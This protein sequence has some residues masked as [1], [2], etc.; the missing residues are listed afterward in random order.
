MK[1][2]KIDIALQAL[3]FIEGF[4]KDR[5][6]D[7][8]HMAAECGSKEMSKT[9]VEHYGLSPATFDTNNHDT[10]MHFAVRGGHLSTIS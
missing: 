7:L 3:P 9:L 10:A 2:D 4:G 6:F 5:H 8:L 1:S